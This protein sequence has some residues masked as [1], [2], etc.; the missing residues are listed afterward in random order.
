MLRLLLVIRSLVF[1][2]LSSEY[3]ILQA[4]LYRGYSKFSKHIF[5]PFSFIHIFFFLFAP[6]FTFTAFE[7][8]LVLFSWWRN[9]IS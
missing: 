1:L 5:G 9:K 7:S 8:P 2:E 6:V 3:K 4:P